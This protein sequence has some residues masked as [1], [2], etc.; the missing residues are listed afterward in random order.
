MCDIYL[1]VWRLF[2]RVIFICMCDIHKCVGCSCMYVR[3]LF[4]CVTFICVCHIH[5]YVWHSYVCGMFM[6]VCDVHL[7]VWRSC[8][9]VTFMCVGYSCICVTH[10]VT[11]MNKTFMYMNV[12]C[13][14]YSCIADIQD[15]SDTHDIHVHDCLCV[16]D[17]HVCQI[18]MYSRYSCTYIMNS[19]TWMCVGYSCIADIHDIHVHEFMMS[20]HE[21]VHEFMMYV[22]EYVHEFMMYVH[23]YRLY[24]NIRHTWT[25]HTHMNVGCSWIYSRG[26]I[27]SCSPT[28]AYCNAHTREIF[29]TRPFLFLNV[30]VLQ[31]A[32]RFIATP[33]H[34]TQARVMSHMTYEWVM[35]YLK[36]TMLHDSFTAD[37]HVSAVHEY[38]APQVGSVVPRE[39]HSL[40]SRRLSLEM[41][42]G[43]WRN[44]VFWNI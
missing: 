34:V 1:Y 28:H 13:V 8:I 39:L 22:H 25:S 18:F 11:H 30:W 29:N 38:I 40:H 31:C 24:M 7:Y 35:S 32:A 4:I 9:C 15:I 42:N 37:V 6:Y 43:I 17:V 27:Y 26:C 44:G 2:V 10:I 41:R 36:D 5:V 23:E 12:M 33:T 21:Y 14:R 20:V 19:C 3:H 16:C